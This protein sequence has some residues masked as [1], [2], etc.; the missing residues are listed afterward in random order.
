M[1]QLQFTMRFRI[2]SLLLVW[3]QTK[4]FGNFI[5]SCCQYTEGHIISLYQFMKRKHHKNIITFRAMYTSLCFLKSNHNPD[6]KVHGANMGPT[7]VLS[8]P[9]GP[10][11]GPMNL[12]IRVVLRLS[13]SYRMHLSESKFCLKPKMNT[14]QLYSSKSSLISW[15][16]LSGP[17]ANK[18]LCSEFLCINCKNILF[19]YYMIAIY[20]TC[21]IMVCLYIIHP[22]RAW[23]HI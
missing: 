13:P 17:A 9:D 4:Y 2:Y 23:N 20:F 7:W 1:H 21:T 18:L 16:C 15:Q 12:A 14:R 3:T 10:H 8:A 5:V 11:V 22:S 6:S 19:L